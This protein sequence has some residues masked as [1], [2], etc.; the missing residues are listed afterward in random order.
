MNLPKTK[1]RTTENRES[2]LRLRKPSGKTLGL[3]VIVLVVFIALM[4]TL[5]RNDTIQ[6]IFPSPSIGSGHKNID[7]KL[8]GLKKLTE[9]EGPVDCIFLGSSLVLRSIDPEIFQQ[10]FQEKTGQKIRCYNFGFAGLIPPFAKVMAEILYEMYSPRLIVLGITPSE[11]QEGIGI[12]MSKRL[13]SNPWFRYRMGVFSIDGWLLDHSYAFRYYL[14]FKYLL[15]HRE[16]ATKQLYQEMRITPYGFGYQDEVMNR[17][18][19]R[20]VQKIKSR[21]INFKPD[22][23][24]YAAMTDVFHL[25]PQVDV[26]MVEVP[27]HPIF[28]TFYSGGPEDHF[29]TLNE[30]SRQ[31]REQ[32]ILFWPTSHLNLIPDEG[33]KNSNHMN[34]RGA[35]VFSRWL[36]EKIGDAVN[37]G[38]LRNPAGEKPSYDIS[39]NKAAQNRK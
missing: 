31:S 26:V 34:F 10:V 16:F 6:S 22:P 37:Q 36:G 14:R 19:K 20:R 29:R 12:K 32:G 11:F 2:T 13:M 27:V 7:F 21:L 5:A 38:K 35:Q 18:R 33:W 24:S 28:H 30:I 8:E 23:D 4:E 17:L 25:R 3:A 9:K 15:E 39:K 1:R